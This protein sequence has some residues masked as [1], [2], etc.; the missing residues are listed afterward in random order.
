M[1]DDANFKLKITA[2]AST[3]NLNIAL[4]IFFIV[5]NGRAVKALG[6]SAF[7]ILSMDHALMF[8]TPRKDSKKLVL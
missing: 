4:D 7:L 1:R 5:S 3:N 8:M 2:S 6:S